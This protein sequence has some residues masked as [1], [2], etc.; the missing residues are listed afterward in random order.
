MADEVD[1][2]VDYYR[3]T[4][5]DDLVVNSTF[6]ITD[7]LKDCRVLFKKL[8]E[9]L[10]LQW[11]AMYEVAVNYYKQFGTINIP[12]KT[13]TAEGYHLGS[14]LDAQRQLRRKGA[15]ALTPERIAKLDELDMRWTLSI[16]DNWDSVSTALQEY[17]D[18]FGNIDVPFSYI[19]S[20]DLELGQYVFL[21]RKTRK[22]NPD[23]W[24]NEKL[25]FLDGLGMIW[26]K[27]NGPTV[28]K[29]HYLS[30]YYEENGNA[31][32]PL[33][34]T[35]KDG[36]KLGRWL[37]QQIEQYNDSFGSSMSDDLIQMLKDYG[38]KL[39]TPEEIEE[40]WLQSYDI[41]KQYFELNGSLEM[42][43][44]FKTE[45]GFELDRWLRH[46]RRLTQKHNKC[47]LPEDKVALLNELEFSWQR[48][49]FCDWDSMYSIAECYYKQFGNLLVPYF[50]EY[51]GYPLGSWISEQRKE[52]KNNNLSEEQINQL[53]TIGM[54]W[55]L[56]DAYRDYLS[57]AKE[58]YSIHNN[59]DV[60]SSENPSLAKW[61]ITIKNKYRLGT[62][63]Q[64]IQRK[65]EAMNMNWDSADDIHWNECFQ[66]AKSY[67][68]TN[69]NLEIAYKYVS[70]DDKP[71]GRWLFHQRQLYQRGKLS[72]EKMALLDGIGFI[73]G[74]VN[75]K[76]WDAFYKLA[77]Q[78]YDEHHHLL[79][80]FDYVLEDGT[81]LG[82]WIQR[83]R[84][85][86][87]IKQLPNNRIE[88]LNLIGM[89]WDATDSD[90]ELS[91]IHA[92]DYL[93]QNGHCAIPAR[94]VSLDGYSLGSWAS[95]MRT[96][97]RKNALS[98]ERIEVLNSIGFCFDME[99]K[100]W[101]DAY[102]KAKEYFDEHH[103][104]ILKYSY[105]TSDGFPLGKWVNTQKKKL[106]NNALSADKA[107]KL[108]QLSIGYWDG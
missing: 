85:K 84:Y 41:A 103:N 7:E 28:K 46:Q 49:S 48:K 75:D 88:R 100:R 40:K 10:S 19:N 93:A 27:V 51:Q 44:L 11:D 15:M 53:S 21:I 104:I 57:V 89:C 59:L 108:K 102:Q 12:S 18:T 90:W 37:H 71:L 79:I 92:K 26:Q 65:L 8:T 105:K 70:D 16:E 87:N 23:F 73:H 72:A 52:K 101:N 39:S 67:F 36:F 1:Y 22:T 30:V 80:P 77:Q 47:K 5:R 78:Y 24:D 106:L 99:E 14:W 45:D 13:K 68:A 33:T 31:D 63:D 42:P 50:F 38:I 55:I 61:L 74:S 43:F 60:D 56:T 29:L 76:K 25:E 3:K 35:T 96:L 95:R 86:R 97:F 69:G 58:Y 107:E 82:S 9:S 32:V 2:Y 4:G 94:Y 54:V 17:H 62:L 81:K 64:D 20:N 66:M 91:L 83:Q 6:E 34:Y 98:S